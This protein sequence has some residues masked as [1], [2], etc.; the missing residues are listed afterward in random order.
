MRHMVGAAERQVLE[1]NDVVLEAR[2]HAEVVNKRMLSRHDRRAARVVDTKCLVLPL[3]EEI[4]HF[5]R[6]TEE[7]GGRIDRVQFWDALQHHDRPVAAVQSRSVEDV[8]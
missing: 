8:V 5:G 7:E 2:V 1:E 6:T 3:Q 4:A